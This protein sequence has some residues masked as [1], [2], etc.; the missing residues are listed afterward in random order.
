[1]SQE[2]IFFS[3][4]T[5]GWYLASVHGESMPVDIVPVERELYDRLVSSGMPLDAGPDGVPF[6]REAPDIGA[7]VPIEVST[8]QAKAA[9][10]ES[11]MLEDVLSYINAP[12][13]DPLVKLAWD[14]VQVF[15]R[16]SL[17]VMAVAIQLDLDE[18]QLDAL[19]IRAAQIVA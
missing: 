6:V 8:F 9:M 16:N 2:Q 18:Q 3:R 19:F 4:S 17:M 12:G 11:G 13:T 15:R 7:L 5:K 1:M 10:L 14:T